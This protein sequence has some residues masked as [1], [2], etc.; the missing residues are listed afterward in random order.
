MAFPKHFKPRSLSA[1]RMEMAHR[2]P[3]AYPIKTEL[4]GSLTAAVEENR[5][6]T[7]PLPHN[8]ET[9][10]KQSIFRINVVF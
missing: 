7:P 1:A 2:A 3:D 6:D 8:S 9:T 4:I 10:S 5:V